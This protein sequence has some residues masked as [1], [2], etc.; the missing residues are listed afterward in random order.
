M[1]PFDA[2]P[3][4]GRRPIGRRTGTNCRHEYGLRLQ[5]LIGLNKCAYC[6]LS[7]VD[8]YDHWLM[9]AVDHVVPVR[10]GEALGITSDW[11][12]D[13]WNT[14]LCCS[15]CSA[16]GSAFQLWPDVTCPDDG[17]QF[18]ALRDRVFAERKKIVLLSHEQELTFFDKKPWALQ[19]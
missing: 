11:L 19:V 12:E 17:E 18:L 4:R 13:Y 8:T 5:R 15:A 6:N 1:M 2:Y 7:L 3:H 16:F 9:M 10:P 14:V